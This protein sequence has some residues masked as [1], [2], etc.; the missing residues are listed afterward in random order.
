MSKKMSYLL[1]IILMLLLT[2]SLFA[3]NFEISGHIN[4]NTTW[5]GVDTVKV[6]NNIFV[7]NSITLTID[8]GIFVEFQ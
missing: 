3:T 6:T 1:V 8:P 2:A 5:T 4:T 7:D